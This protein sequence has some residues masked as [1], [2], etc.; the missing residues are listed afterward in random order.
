MLEVVVSAHE[1]AFHSL[2]GQSLALRVPVFL[3]QIEVRVLYQ[4]ELYFTDD[5]VV[6]EG[7]GSRESYF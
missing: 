2:K 1:L 7:V 6:C 3:R 5:S 4:V